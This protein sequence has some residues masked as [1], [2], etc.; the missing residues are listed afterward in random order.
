MHRTGGTPECAD[1]YVLKFEGALLNRPLAIA[2]HK[3]TNMDAAA[4]ESFGYATRLIENSSREGE[5]AA[6]LVF[7]WTS[8][9]IR[10]QLHLGLKTHMMVI[11]IVSAPIHTTMSLQ[12]HKFFCTLYTAIYY[13]LTHDTVT[14][15]Q[16]PCISPTPTLHLHD[17]L[18]PDT[19]TVPAL[20]FKQDI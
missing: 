11:D 1:L 16:T 18:S 14:C 10:L 7:P 5:F 17:C 4:R 20:V 13:L 15:L 2:D 8:E 3:K 9:T 19:C 12:L 6:C